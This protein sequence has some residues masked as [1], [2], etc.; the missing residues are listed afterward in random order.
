MSGKWDVNDWIEEIASM[1]VKR[2]YPTAVAKDTSL[3]LNEVFEYLLEA[4]KDGRLILFWEVRCPNLECVRSITFSPN[5][6]E[7]GDVRC[8]ICG[9]EIEITPD[10]VYP[11]FE[12]APEY[13]TRI[14]QKK[15]G[16]PAV[17]FSTPK[18]W[19]SSRHQF[20]HMGS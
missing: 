5:K 10:I 9:E 20:A 11:V 13:K 15:M 2:F 6:I 1:P 16:K 3:P 19:R 12:V 14:A 8:V 17:S 18:V 4:V 7:S